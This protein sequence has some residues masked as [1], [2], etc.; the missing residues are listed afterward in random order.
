MAR[1]RAAT[2]VL[3]PLAAFCASG[4]LKVTCGALA[5]LVFLGVLRFD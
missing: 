5:L 2:I 1:I 3:V 4:D